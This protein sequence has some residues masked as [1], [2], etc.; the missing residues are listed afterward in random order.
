MKIY[1]VAYALVNSVWAVY[2]VERITKTIYQNLLLWYALL[3]V[4]V[5]ECGVKADNNALKIY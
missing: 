2:L 3:K 1:Y 4:W 5:N